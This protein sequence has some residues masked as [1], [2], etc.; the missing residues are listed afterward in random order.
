MASAADRVVAVLRQL[1]DGDVLSASVIAARVNNDGGRPLTVATIKR[2][3]RAMSR[4]REVDAPEWW[5]VKYWSAM[6]DDDRAREL[7]EASGG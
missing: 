1:A 6:T 5:R 4:R 2:A 3:L 7:R